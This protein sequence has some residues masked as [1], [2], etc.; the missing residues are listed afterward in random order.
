MI[1]YCFKCG[2]EIKWDDKIELEP[3]SCD[4]CTP[5]IGYLMN[6]LLRITRNRNAKPIIYNI[7]G[8]DEK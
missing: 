3:L 6:K 4:K 5:R 8:D 1:K 2:K 7:I